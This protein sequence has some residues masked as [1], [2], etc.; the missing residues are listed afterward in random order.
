M[1]AN[2]TFMRPTTP[3]S[4]AS[5]SVVWRISSSTAGGTLTGGSEHAESPEWTPASSMCSMI[6]AITTSVPSA[7]ASTSNSIALGGTRR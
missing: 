5:A 2:C 7:T 1:S 3:S 4:R 6:P